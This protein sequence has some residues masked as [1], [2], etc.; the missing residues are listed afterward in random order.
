M[1]LRH[2]ACRN[3]SEVRLTSASTPPIRLQKRGYPNTEVQAG[4]SGQF[5]SNYFLCEVV[6]ITIPFHSQ[7]HLSEP[8]HRTT[9]AQGAC[10]CDLTPACLIRPSI[11]G[12]I[13]LV[14]FTV[15]SPSPRESHRVGWFFRPAILVHFRI[16]F[17]MITNSC[18]R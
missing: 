11:R 16:T 10:Q 13:A 17:L 4:I 5:S 8:T 15:N 7:F 9:S 1:Y 12:A 18:S 3:W 6:L 2:L 14:Q